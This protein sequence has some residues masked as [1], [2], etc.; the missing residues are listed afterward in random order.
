MKNWSV[1]VVPLR[2]QLTGNV[3]HGLRLLFAA[4]GVVLLIAC[5]NVATLNMARA[6][7]RRREI[8][9][10]MALGAQ[11]SRVIRQ[12]ISESCLLAL[13][14]GTA[15]FVL[16]Y[17]C[18]AVLKSITPANLIP[19]DSL[20]LD[21]RV[22]AFATAVSML[23]GLLFGTIPAIDGARTAPRERLQDG[24]STV[25][26]SGQRGFARRA[27]V[28]TEVALALVLV[29]GAG[30]LIRS[31]QRLIAVDPGFRPEGVLTA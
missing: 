16:G 7:A 2:A 14:S 20:H 6:S 12:V 8:A 30:L 19:L 3:A 28:V 1:N 22:F 11:A 26:G 9:I 5:A 13:L 17:M 4:M 25:A 27:L 24:T 18:L 15:G 23:T 29:S 21:A 31:F 10:R